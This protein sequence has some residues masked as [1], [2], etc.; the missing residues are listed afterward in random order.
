MDKI[1]LLSLSNDLKRITTAIQEGSFENAE[2]FTKE[3]KRWIKNDLQDDYLKQLMGKI[4]N[5]L[6]EK[7]NLKKAEDCLLY[8]VLLQNQALYSKK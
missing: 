4:A 5:S 8:S 6:E 2:L 1:T 7:N 3:A